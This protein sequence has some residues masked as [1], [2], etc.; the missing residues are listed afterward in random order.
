MRVSPCGA[1]DLLPRGLF[2]E[3]TGAS[4][5]SGT[6][7]KAS[8]RNDVSTIGHVKAYTM[9]SSESTNLNWE[10]LTGAVTT[11]W[12][13]VRYAALR[14]LTG[15]CAGGRCAGRSIV[16]APPV[17]SLLELVVKRSPL[18]SELSGLFAST[19]YQLARRWPG[20]VRYDWSDWAS[21]RCFA[22]QQR[23]GGS[24]LRAGWSQSDPSAVPL[25]APST[26]SVRS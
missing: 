13:S 7:F 1:S 11:T 14:L 20:G 15:H 21:E 5:D 16:L 22:R 2:L 3:A 12:Q 4:G 25:M 19:E 23:I 26:P 9:T 17:P 6:L 18:R 10:A 8:R 24:D